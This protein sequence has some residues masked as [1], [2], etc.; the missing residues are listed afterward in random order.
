MRV[1]TRGAQFPVRI[2]PLVQQGKKL[3]G[4]G[5]KGEGQFG[6]SVA[7]SANGN[8]ALVGAIGDHEQ[9]G[10]A[11]TFT[12]SGATWSQHGGKLKGSGATIET[13]FG[14]SVALAGNGSSALISGEG[15][16]GGAGAAYVFTPTSSTWVQQGEK[17]TGREEKGQG[18]FG[19]SVAL[20]S[21]GS[22][23]FVGGGGDHNFKGAAWPF[24]GS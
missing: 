17:L 24:A 12:R 3:V 11:W 19:M 10:A 8:T 5:E 18:L 14:F 2:D 21:E 20:S 16:N 9:I 22:T 1:D 4:G 6:I 7:L 13:L 23:G 15:D